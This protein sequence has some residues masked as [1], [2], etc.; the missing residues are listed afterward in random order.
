MCRRVFAVQLIARIG[1]CQQ[2][3]NFQAPG[4]WQI[5]SN[6]PSASL[7]PG[8]EAA[9]PLYLS[10]PSP[11]PNSHSPQPHPLS[12]PPQRPTAT[13]PMGNLCGKE[14]KDN[15]EGQGRTLG[16]APAP[17][18]KASV[19]SSASAPKRT[20][21]GPPRTLGDGNTNNDPKAAAAAAAEVRTILSVPPRQ[22]R[23][24]QPLA[25]STMS[26]HTGT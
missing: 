12:P 23:A 22:F 7:S 8:H 2:P 11:P 25:P 9:L 15:F 19:P 24:L 16:S 14:S 1:I 13:T 21:G 5:L 3:S 10:T 26:L 17:A 6:G 4:P 20:V 18:T